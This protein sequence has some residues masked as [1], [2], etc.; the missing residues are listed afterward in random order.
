MQGIE[1]LTTDAGDTLT[2]EF[3]STSIANGVRVE[4]ESQLQFEIDYTPHEDNVGNAAVYAE[5][6]LLYTSQNGAPQTIAAAPE[7]LA[8]KSYVVESDLAVTPGAGGVFISEFLIKRWRAYADDTNGKDR[9][10]CFSVPLGFRRV[11]LSVKEVGM[12]TSFGTFR[13][14]VG[15]QRI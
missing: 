14:A 15:R 4:S 10:P 2:D 7:T 11:K 13:A 1:L 5:W 8:W 9:D 3:T 12:G 6:E